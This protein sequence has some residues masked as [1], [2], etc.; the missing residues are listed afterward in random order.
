MQ[1][2]TIDAHYHFGALAIRTTTAVLQLRKMCCGFGSTS[3]NALGM[4]YH[5]V[6]AET[7]STD[8]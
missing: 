1:H 6:K 7:C 8:N 4:Y 2:N 3:A 5:S